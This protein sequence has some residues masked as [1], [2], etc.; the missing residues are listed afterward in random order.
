MSMNGFFEFE[1]KRYSSGEFELKDN[2]LYARATATIRQFSDFSHIS[3]DV[4]KRKGM[5]G[6][7]VHKSIHEYIEGGFPFPSVQAQG[8]M[9]SFYQWE[10]AVNP[11]FLESEVRYYCDKRMLSGGVDALIKLKGK[12]EAILVDFKTSS[13]ESPITWQ[14]QGHLYHYLLVGAGKVISPRMLFIKL[15]RYGHEPTVFEYKVNSNCMNRCLEAVESFWEA[16]K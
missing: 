10:V 9:K 5:L 3:E 12:E 2:K 11:R 4:L 15:D 8:Y 13:Q 16:H 1:G 6:T 7:E 14:M